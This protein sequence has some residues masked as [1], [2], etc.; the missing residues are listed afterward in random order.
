MDAATR[1]ARA[2][3]PSAAQPATLVPMSAPDELSPPA[4]RWRWL[5]RW[6]EPPWRALLTWVALSALTGWALDHRAWQTVGKMVDFFYEQMGWAL[7]WALLIRIPFE[8]KQVA[9]SSSFLVLV[10]WF[11]PIVFRLNLARG[12]VW[13]VLRIVPFMVVDV[14]L[15]H[16]EMLELQY[17]TLAWSAVAVLVLS[18]WRSRPW[19]TML[20]GALMSGTSYASYG[21]REL[22]HGEYWWWN[23]TMTLPYAA[24]LLYGTRRLP[25]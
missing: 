3:L 20:G 21:V 4:P 9:K 17:A 13:I 16:D 1:A 6:F 22:I 2:R 7:G 5:D 15:R 8:I 18:G 19:M 12:L 11:E 24:V 25:R 10:F 14:F 23:L